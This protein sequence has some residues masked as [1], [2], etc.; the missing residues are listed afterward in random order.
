M[1]K[2]LLAILVCPACKGKLLLDSDKPAL[3][4]LVEGLSFP[5]CDEIPVMLI[6]EATRLSLDEVEALKARG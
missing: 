4:C 6:D 3:V 5:I 2:Q 1:D